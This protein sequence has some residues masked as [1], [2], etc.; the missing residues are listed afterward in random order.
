MEG[1]LRQANDF[2]QESSSISKKQLAFAHFTTVTA[3]LGLTLGRQ[4]IDS[5]NRIVSTMT[6]SCVQELCEKR[7]IVLNARLKFDM[8]FFLLVFMLKPEMDEKMLGDDLEKYF[9]GQVWGKSIKFEGGIED[10]D[11]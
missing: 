8:V 5:A 11:K 1:I 7:F 6:D 9:N 3:I 10:E 4:D 2:L